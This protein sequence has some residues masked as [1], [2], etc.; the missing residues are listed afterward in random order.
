MTIYHLCIGLHLLA[1]S[2]W[3]G[4]MFVWSLIVGPAMKR[5]EPAATAEMLRE[6]SMFRGG[7]GWPALAVLVPTGLYMLDVR[8]IGVGDLLSGAAFH[9]SQGVV[10][11]VKLSCV[12]GM[13]V[14]QSIFS[15]RSAPGAI[16]LNMALAL[17]IM[18]A[19]VLIVRGSVW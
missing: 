6:R 1:L 14:Y 18:G 8:G 9:G 2:L 11:A 10:L 13:I 16:Y 4:H 5:I 19:S 12:A 7:L 3:L 17:T 15:H